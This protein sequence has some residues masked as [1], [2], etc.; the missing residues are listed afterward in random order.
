MDGFVH[1]TEGGAKHGRLGFTRG[2][3]W[4]IGR[5]GTS[6]PTHFQITCRSSS[7]AKALTV[8]IDMRCVPLCTYQKPTRH[9]AGGH[10]L[11][12]S[13]HIRSQ[14]NIKRADCYLIQL[15]ALALKHSLCQSQ[16][17]RYVRAQP[18]RRRS[19][20]LP[21]FFNQIPAGGPFQLFRCRFFVHHLVRKHSIVQKAAV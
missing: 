7:F 8:D 18:S 10:K 4:F 1:G 5:A 2:R 6:V 16:S 11:E 13:T 14:R 3:R 15:R 19:R 20:T 12:T 9:V 21:E 17:E